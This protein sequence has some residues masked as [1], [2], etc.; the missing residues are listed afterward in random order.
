MEYYQC[1]SEYYFTAKN[2]LKL[3]HWDN[4]GNLIA[5]ILVDSSE[6]ETSWRKR[7][8]G[9][10]SIF[11]QNADFIGTGLLYYSSGELKLKCNSHKDSTYNLEFFKSG[12]VKKKFYTYKLS[13]IQFGDYLEFDSVGNII[14]KGEYYNKAQ[15]KEFI[16]N[17]DAK[18][19]SVYSGV[20]HGEWRYFDLAKKLIRTEFYIHGILVST[21][22]KRSKK[23][24]N[25]QH[26][27]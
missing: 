12:A 15:L 16:D 5:V 8:N 3:V 22:I 23:E 18:G 13:D 2:S 7:P 26:D 4:S 1:S 27:N 6:N 24:L 21:N 20:K 11:K 17:E 14:C 10:I 9:E 19:K 25:I